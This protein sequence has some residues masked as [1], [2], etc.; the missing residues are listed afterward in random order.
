MLKHWTVPEMDNKKDNIDFEK[1]PVKETK[2]KTIVLLP[3]FTFYKK[4]WWQY[5]KIYTI[6]WKARV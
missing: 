2:Q 3:V 1:I 4:P 5:Q 6:S